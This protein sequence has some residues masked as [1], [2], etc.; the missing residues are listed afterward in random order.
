MSSGIAGLG[1]SEKLQ[2]LRA[3]LPSVFL[4]SCTGLLVLAIKLSALRFRTAAHP[5][6][7]E[8]ILRWVTSASW[9]SSVAV[10]STVGKAISQ[11]ERGNGGHTHS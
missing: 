2:H 1:N 10:S 6:V 3:F 9:A 11:E 7:A 4:P 8:S 5:I